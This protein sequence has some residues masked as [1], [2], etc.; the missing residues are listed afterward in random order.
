MNADPMMPP[1][2]Y[3][4]FDWEGHAVRVLEAVGD[5][6]GLV[7]LRMRYRCERCG[8]EGW[9]GCEVGVEGPKELRDRKLFIASPFSTWCPKDIGLR[10]C[11]GLYSHFR[12]KDDQEFEPRQREEGELVFVLPGDTSTWWHGATL[13]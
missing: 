12:M 13:G 11:G 5:R 6:K 3:P 2:G 7:W 4:K 8:H 9:I 1:P 10:A